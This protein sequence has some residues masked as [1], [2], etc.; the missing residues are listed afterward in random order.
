MHARKIVARILGPCLAGLHAKRAQALMRAVS[1]ELSGGALSLSALA[2]AMHASSAL[3]HRVKSMD[4]LLGNAGLQAARAELYGTVAQRWLTGLTQ[5]LLVVDWSDL[6]RDQK[7]Q[8]LRASGVVEGRSVTLYEEVH[9]QRRLGSRAVHRGFL[10]R[11][12]Q[13]LPRGCCPIVMTD[14]GFRSTWFH[15]VAEHGWQWIGRIRNR[16]YVARDEGDWISA[17][18]LH[19]RAREQ[20][21]DLGHWRYVRSHPTPCRLVLVK[22]VPKGRSRRTIYGQ[23]MKSRTSQKQARA[24]REPWLLAASP[25]LD[26][27]EAATIVKLYAQCMRIEQSFR[28]TKNLRLGQGLATTRSRTPKRLE[29]LLLIAHPGA[30]VQRLIGED[31]KTRQLE[32]Q[33]SST[34][35]KTRP[36]ISVLTLARRLLA[37]PTQWLNQLTP[38]ASIPPLRAQAQHACAPQ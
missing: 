25:G 24:G 30:F 19:A 27:L 26:H 18:S 9:A 8:W 11:V 7:W 37:A 12:A 33:F 22:Q 16:D 34:C 13:L 36:E 17:T 4:R 23:K 29:V 28:D 3:R 21:Q 2:L 35:R 1:A 14:A 20:T 32:L 5:V 10:K 6:T 31:A 15:L 38:W